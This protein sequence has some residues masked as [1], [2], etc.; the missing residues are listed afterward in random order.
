M[1]EAAISS[2]GVDIDV[3]IVCVKIDLGSVVIVD[4]V[5]VV[6]TGLDTVCV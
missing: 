3:G 4:I 1:V 6:C 2:A 5:S